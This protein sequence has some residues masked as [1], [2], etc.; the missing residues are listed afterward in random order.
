[1]GLPLS[2]TSD[3]F[4]QR[5]VI[6]VIFWEL[7]SRIK[8]NKHPSYKVGFSTEKTSMI[9]EWDCYSVSHAFFSAS[10]LQSTEEDTKGLHHT[11]SWHLQ[12]A[13]KWQGLR[14]VMVHVM[15]PEEAEE[16]VKLWLPNAETWHLVQ[17][18]LQFSWQPC[19]AVFDVPRWRQPRSLVVISTPWK[20][21]WPQVE[22]EL[23]QEYSYC[24]LYFW[25][26]TS[27]HL[28]MLCIYFYLLS[29]YFICTMLELL[30]LLSCPEVSFGYSERAMVD[31]YQSFGLLL[32]C[33]TEACILSTSVAS[34][35]D[36]FNTDT[37]IF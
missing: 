37:L 34:E 29:C 6:N 13:W 23:C 15:W 21:K 9:F 35:R 4:A 26:N 30:A 32:S 10:R 27:S 12:E 25:T 36:N 11:N 20:E 31:E 19:F 17:W 3:I 1:M 24:K 33:L 28:Y 14:L 2:L 7:T 18:L 16:G 22:P 5:E 8:L